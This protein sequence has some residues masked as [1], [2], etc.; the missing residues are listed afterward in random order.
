[1][2]AP[3]RV[4][5]PSDL[6][7]VLVGGSAPAVEWLQ[8]R[9]GL[10]LSIVGRLGG[11]SFPRT[12]RGK[13]KFPGMTITYAL[14]ERYEEI[15]KNEPHRA[16]AITKARA[17]RLLVDEHGNV[18]G[19]EYQKDG[20][21]HQEHGA[22][23]I[24]TGGYGADYSDDSLLKKFRP[25]LLALPT[26]NGEHCTGDGIKMALAIGAGTVDMDAV[27]VHPTG[28]VDINEPDAKVKFLAAEALR[29]TGALL[30]DVTGE[31]FCNE[32]G[33]RDYVSACM[34]KGKGPFRLVLNAKAAAQIMWH[35]KHYVGRGLMKRYNNA[36]ELAADMKIPAAKLQGTLDAYNAVCTSK[37]DPWG[38]KFFDAY[39]FEMNEEYWV[40]IVVPVVHYCMGGLH[41]NTDATVLN[42]SG[43]EIH[44]L[45]ATGEALGG[46]HGRN[47]LGG[48]SLLD[49][50]V[51]GRVAGATASRYL[52]EQAVAGRF[53][54][55]VGSASG[56]D[57]RINAAPGKVD[58]SISF[59][60]AGAATATA[61]TSSSTSSGVSGGNPDI[62]DN[63][64]SPAG[65]SAAAAAA[66]SKRDTE[67]TLAD[68]AK[69]NSEKDCWVVVNGQV[70][71]VTDFLKDHP[72]GKKAI[73]LFAGRDASEE[74]NMLH[75]G[76]S[77]TRD[78]ESS[79]ANVD[80]ACVCVQLMSSRSTRQSRSSAASSRSPSSKLRLREAPLNPHAPTTAIPQPPPLLSTS[81]TRGRRRVS[82]PSHRNPSKTTNTNNDVALALG[83]LV[84]RVAAPSPPHQHHRRSWTTSSRPRRQSNEVAS[85]S[86]SA[87]DSSWSVWES[88]SDCRSSISSCRCARTRRRATLCKHSAGSAHHRRRRPHRHLHPPRPTN[89]RIN[90]RGSNQRGVSRYTSNGR[91]REI[92]TCLERS[93]LHIDGFQEAHDRAIISACIC[94]EVSWYSRCLYISLLSEEPFM[95]HYLHPYQQR[96]CLE[97][98]ATKQ[99]GCSRITID[100][101]DVS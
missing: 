46:V 24:A 36:A 88:P 38:K 20:S 40:A 1:M 81:P 17:T 29:G 12:H 57:V 77:C 23:I 27:Q 32:L 3:L 14:M 52:L 56:A 19:V 47:R 69:H 51:F 95:H 67:Y 94:F 16:R 91:E 30:L 45:Y 73:L 22:V 92:V 35:C 21:T 101:I 70:L 13:E 39:P 65:G 5:P 11:H 72:G 84:I 78:I 66:A 90:S 68:V 6:A 59:S 26:T 63:N 49:C 75:K 55:S 18:T 87:S 82:S 98:A 33:T 58:I 25:E 31:R 7:R 8:E 76:M 60:G 41:I 9:F 86:A 54:S 53:G 89:H 34:F 64:N 83:S 15:C 96:E 37:N 28:L 10:D 50:V 43:A 74:F 48:S 2:L 42:A 44:G 62:A 4:A 99:E 97:D 61:T 79:D 80:L 71:N 85:S 100:H 93:R